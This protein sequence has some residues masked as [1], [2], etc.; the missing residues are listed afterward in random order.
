MAVCKRFAGP[1]PLKRQGQ[2]ARTRAHLNLR[3]APAETAV[4]VCDQ[5]HRRLR[6]WKGHAKWVL[7]PNYFVLDK[8][9]LVSHRLMSSNFDYTGQAFND[10]RYVHVAIPNARPH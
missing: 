7:L 6:G 10:T 8:S 2:E 1:G 9:Q 4:R 3:P 5:P